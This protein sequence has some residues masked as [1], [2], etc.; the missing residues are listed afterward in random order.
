VEQLDNLLLMSGND[1][2]F[3]M[4]R[5][6]IH[7]PTLSEISYIGEEA[8]QTGSRFLLFNK[9]NLDDKDKS[10]LLQQS[11][12]NI[13]MSVMNSKEGAKHKTDTMLV[14]TLIF[15]KFNVKINKDKIL[16]QADK[17][18]TS[19]NEY[20]FEEFQ[21][22]IRQIFCLDGMGGDDGQYKPADD[23]ARKIAEKFQK[24]RN[25]VSSMKGEQKKINIFERYVS[26]LSVGLQKDKND[27]MKYTVYQIMDEMER[28]RLKQDFDIYIRAKLAGAQDMEEVKN[29]MDELHP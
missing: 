28:F 4:G 8:F 27:L 1:I 14:L 10:E 26:I 15:P 21:D 17:F 11:N 12:F 5:C 2:P 7:P 13:F 25:K 22:I 18:E 24:G 3:R 23:L 19:V 9:E 29:W 20:N 6:S 16:L